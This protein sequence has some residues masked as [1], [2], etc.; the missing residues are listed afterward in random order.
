MVSL[1]FIAP[2]IDRYGNAA[3][4]WISL[5]LPYLS[6]LPASLAGRAVSAAVGGNLGGVL[7]GAA[8]L[9]FY[10]FL[11]SGLLWRRFAA[12][13]RGEELSETPAPVQAI[14]RRKSIEQTEQLE[15]LR[16][17]SPQVAAVLRKEFR[18][19]TRNA[20]A[21][22]MLLVPPLLV[23]VFTW[24]FPGRNTAAPDQEI[25]PDFFFPGM[26][27]YLILFLMAPSYNCF[28]YEG[29]G[30]QSYY[31]APV[32]FREVFLG[33]NLMLIAVLA[34]EIALC[35]LVLVFRVGLPSAHIFV[36]TLAAIVFAVTGQLSIANWSSLSFPRKLEFGQMRGQRQSGMAVLIAFGVQIVLGSISALILLTGRWTGNP[37]LPAEVFAGLAAAAL[38]GYLASLDAL[39]HLAE[40][41]K[42]T[43]IEA[44]CR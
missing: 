4:P 10:M 38:A 5:L 7:V 12:Q 43:L 17:L 2:A 34:L 35:M 40:K 22:L 11:F 13:L 21:F 1:Q 42:E 37:W 39:S 16:L 18:Y 20:F 28:A 3:R 27:A 26:V 36:S 25:S 19:L 41:K 44:L 23:L 24:Q 6:P 9:T 31:M 32:R 30:I 33:K 15:T 8:G 14:A 29:R